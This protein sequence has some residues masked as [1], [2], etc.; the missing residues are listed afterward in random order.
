[1]A[2]TL[3]E[4]FDNG[5]SNANPANE[6]VVDSLGPPRLKMKTADSS[7]IDNGNPIPKPETGTK[8]SF[9]KQVYLKCSVAP[10]TQMDNFK[11]YSDGGGFGTGIT[12]SVGNQFPTKTK[13]SNAGYVVAT[14][15][16]GENGDEMVATHGGLTS[17]SDAFTKTSTSPLLVSC[18]EAGNLINA[19]GEC[20][21]YIVLQAEVLSTASAGTP[22]NETVT[23]MWDEI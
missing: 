21:N 3:Q 19:V 22:S 20:T 16:I 6:T 10:A 17:S 1:M 15:T 11:W 18:G 14:G 8:Y 5:G 7:V 2:G 23:W 13:S 12:L 9:W 4:C